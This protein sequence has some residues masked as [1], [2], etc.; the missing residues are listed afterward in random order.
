MCVC[1]DIVSCG[2]GTRCQAF[3]KWGNRMMIWLEF[4]ISNREKIWYSLTEKWT[5]REGWNIDN[6]TWQMYTNTF[7]W[8]HCHAIT[9]FVLN[10]CLSCSSIQIKRV[11]VFLLLSFGWPQVRW[12]IKRE[13]FITILSW[14]FWQV[15]IWLRTAQVLR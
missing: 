5:M 8:N 9:V 7:H 3:E 13:R 6:T 10:H 2:F 14:K 11:R 12:F 15:F 1:V 4:P